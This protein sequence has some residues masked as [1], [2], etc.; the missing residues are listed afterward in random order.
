MFLTSIIVAVT[1]M[2]KE[3]A[4]ESSVRSEYT[5]IL[6]LEFVWSNKMRATGAEVTILRLKAYPQAGDC[7][8]VIVLYY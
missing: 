8:T 5:P 6:N 2:V 3:V 4:V 7:T 1:G